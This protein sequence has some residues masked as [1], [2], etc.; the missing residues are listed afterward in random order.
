M[1]IEQVLI[2]RAC[3]RV[4][5]DA[6]HA[7]DV[8]DHELLARCFTD[9]CTFIRPSTWPDGAIVGRRALSDI[10]NA[11]DPRYA[12]RHVISNLRIS[13]LGRTE[14]RGSSLFCNFAAISEP[15]GIAPAA[16]GALRSVGKYED[17]FVLRDDRWQIHR[18]VGRFVFGAKFTV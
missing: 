16:N 5:L 15:G 14:A 6:S 13:V 3:E 7:L 18:R 2:E 11:R 12:G 1:N 17:V 10:I 8:A 9:D 4:A